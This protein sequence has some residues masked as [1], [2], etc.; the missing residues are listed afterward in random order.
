MDF[1]LDE[2]RNRRLIDGIRAIGILLVILFHVL[3]GLSRVVPEAGMDRL[4]TEF[5]R[6][7][8]IAWQA[9]GSEMIF[10]ISGFL[11]SRLLLREFRLHG[12]INIREYLVR[13]ASR[14]LPMYAIALIVYASVAEF[15]F[16]ELILNLLFV[17]KIFGVP[18]IVPQ[19][20]ALEVL[21]QA[22]L[23]LPFLVMVVVRRR[24]PLAVIAILLCLSVVLRYRGLA[25][26]PAAYEAPFHALLHGGRAT[27]TQQMLYTLLWYRATPFL[28]GLF[29]AFLSV[30]HG[31]RLWV[32][33]TRKILVTGVLLLGI[34]LIAA[35]GFLPVQ[36]QHAFLYLDAVGPRV[37]LWFWTLQRPLF[38]AGLAGILLALLYS[39]L[40]VPGFF[41]RCLRWKLWSAISRNIYS[42][43]LFHLVWMIPA[44]VIVLRTTDKN[45]IQVVSSPQVFVIFALTTVFSVL[46][47]SL[48]T[49]FVEIPSKRWLRRRYSR[50]PGQD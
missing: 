24:Q 45:N 47:A 29:V 36:D 17:S 43:Y 38:V 8:N 39:P 46:F 25:A 19:G 1:I 5:P 16:R 3:F 26:D 28:A 50:E 33:F 44:A 23:I 12:T 32:V 48:L 37:W 41:A 31:E 40:G 11:L 30:F 42:I 6:A 13:R 27:Q 35:S 18:T 14:I 21:V 2:D 20:W 34:A 49:C 9:L 15:G 10:F 7:L 22:Y 4:I